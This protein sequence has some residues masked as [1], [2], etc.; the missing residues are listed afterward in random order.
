MN[1]Y[2]KNCTFCSAIFIFEI[3]GKS[4]SQKQIASIPNSYVVKDQIEYGYLNVVPLW[5]F[6]LNY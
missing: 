3:G 1:K 5:A 6:G 2:L 4:K